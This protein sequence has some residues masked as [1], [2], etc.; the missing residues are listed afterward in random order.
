MY[1]GKGVKIDG[2]T[3]DKPAAVAGI[4]KG[5][6]ILKLGNISIDTMQDYMKA[7]AAFK[8]GDRTTVEINRAGNI[9]IKEVIF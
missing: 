7:L 5:D 4:Q 3:P 6:C 9:L 2:V 8:K 1:E